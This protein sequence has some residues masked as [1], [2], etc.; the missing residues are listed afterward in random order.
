MCDPLQ[1]FFWE[2]SAMS[3]Q[4]Y[5]RDITLSA[6]LA[7]NCPLPKA[8][9]TLNLSYHAFVFFEVVPSTP[10][11]VGITVTLVALWILLRS[12]NKGEPGLDAFPPFPPQ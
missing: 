12:F 7:D 11:T 9:G 6:R 3:Q 1:F 4:Q 2:F 5:H 8:S 10:I